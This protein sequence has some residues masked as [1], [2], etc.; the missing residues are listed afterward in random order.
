M[1]IQ[2]LVKEQNIAQENAKQLIEAFGA[3]FT[4]AGEIL[5]NY[6]KIIVTDE[7]QIDVMAEAKK[8]RLALKKVRTTVENRRKELKEDS[9]RTGKAI[10]GVA[11][12]IKDTIVPAEEYLEQQE[13]F[14]EIKESKRLA[15][16]KESRTQALMQY[17]E[18]ENT[19]VY[20]LT[21]ITEEQFEKLLS[22]LKTAKE[23]QEAK[24]KAY[25][26]EQKRLVA[27]KEAEDIRIRKENELL[28]AELDA[29]KAEEQE[30]ARKEHDAIV[31]DAKLAL[32]PDREKLLAF[33]DSLDELEVPSA[34]S[35]ASRIREHLRI[36]TAMYRKLIEEEM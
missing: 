36:S 3:P 7:S 24:D 22:D 34:T 30:A 9:L 27:E 32:A 14:A 15:H 10:D 2:L 17:T 29:K 5:A 23:L 1:D 26:V 25:E 18:Y 6:E 28:K 4:E 33:V 13:K 19:L 20:E 21:T 12:Y 31:A 16:L 8:N 11:K 35:V